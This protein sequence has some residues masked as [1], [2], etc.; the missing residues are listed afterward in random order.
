MAAKM[1][2]F[3]QKTYTRIISVYIEEVFQILMAKVMFL[4][5]AQN[6]VASLKRRDCF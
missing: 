4:N 6:R 2:D 1:A 5:K 3:L